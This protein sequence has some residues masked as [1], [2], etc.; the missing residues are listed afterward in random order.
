MQL[1]L[2]AGTMTGTAQPDAKAI[3]TVV[4]IVGYAVY[5]MPMDSLD[6]AAERTG[7]RFAQYVVGTP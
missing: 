1:T 5:V 2:L 4:K 6:V 3:Q 7:G